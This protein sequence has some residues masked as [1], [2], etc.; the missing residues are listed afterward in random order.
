MAHRPGIGIRKRL[1]YCPAARTPRFK[2]FPFARAI[3]IA[4]SRT[5]P[6]KTFWCNRK[7]KL[8]VS[9]LSVSRAKDPVATANLNSQILQFRL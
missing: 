2:D 3:R 6:L 7:T 1:I 9:R 8:V 5:C 4:L